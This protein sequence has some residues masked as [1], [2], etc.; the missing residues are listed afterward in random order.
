MF[1]QNAPDGHGSFFL[2]KYPMEEYYP[3][4]INTKLIIIAALISLIISIFGYLYYR[5]VSR[6][7]SIITPMMN[8]LMNNSPTP[9]PYLDMTVPYLRA[10]KYESN[11]TE[12][13]WVGDNG[14]YSSYL[15]SYQSDG[16][17]I[18]GLITRPNGE[19]PIGGWPAIVFVH[20]Y[21]PPNEYKTLEKYVDYIDYLASSGFVVFK[22]DLRGHGE[23]EGQAGGSYYGSEY[24]IDALN[25][26]AALEKAD[27]INPKAIG[28]WGHSMAGNVVSRSMAVK[29][30]IPAV[31][32][33]AGAGYS[34]ADLQKYGIQDT[35]FRAQPVQP[36]VTRRPNRRRE[37]FTKIGSPS[38]QNIFWQQVAPIYYFNEMKGAIQIHHAVD[39]TFVNVGYSRDLNA[40]LD[41]SNVPHEYYEYPTGGHNIAGESFNTAMQRTVE[42]FQKYLK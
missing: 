25:A 39:D 36:N 7:D 3:R 22:I 11:L 38:A 1:H 40:V 33:W 18:N 41:K 15:T 30:T 16:L 32:I 24:I 2:V 5:D 27:F 37:I 42:F 9:F 6:P 28:M 23:S 26:Y 12:L 8:K 17:K 19:M 21:I 10:K 34:Y 4:K 29:P 13:E 31:V 14:M 20:G 35:S